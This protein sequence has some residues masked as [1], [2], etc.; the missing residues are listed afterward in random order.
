MAEQTE[1]KTNDN[2]RVNPFTAAVSDT[3][4]AQ[5]IGY[6]WPCN[7]DTWQHWHAVQTQWN[8]GMG[9]ATGL[10]YAGVRAYLD[11]QTFE[12]D[13]RSET[14]KGICAAEH[15]TLDAWA[16]KSKREKQP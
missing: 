9:G 5:S 14:F 2:E 16:E 6:L 3:D 8:V 7:V 1:A 13:A 11:E 15:A 10:D 12:G 4:G